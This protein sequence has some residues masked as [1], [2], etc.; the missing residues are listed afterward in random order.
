MI[1]LNRKDKFKDFK[2]SLIDENEKNYGSEIREKYGNQTV[3]RSN[4]KIKGMTQERYNEVKRLS[5]EVNN[6]LKTAFE[7]G[8][9]HS[10]L[11][12]QACELHKKWLC[13]FWDN[14]CKKAHISVTQMY[15]D[16]PRF[17]EYYDKIAPGCAIFLRDAVQIYC[18]V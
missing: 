10:E 9:P 6:T 7:Q 2:Q 8:D 13:C 17:T 16:D 12:Q 15:V 1:I 4:A 18:D 11:A 3:D 5:Q 14:Y